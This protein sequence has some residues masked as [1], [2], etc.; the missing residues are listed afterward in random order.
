M[1][2][3]P[4]L[5]VVGVGAAVFAAGDGA[6]EVGAVGV[7]ER[8]GLVVDPFSFAEVAASEGGMAA[9]EHGDLVIFVV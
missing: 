7:V 9:L 6:A 5:L 2:L 4:P 1:G 3:P 8:V